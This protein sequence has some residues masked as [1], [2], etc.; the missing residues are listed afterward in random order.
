MSK[1]K[2]SL[3][4]VKDGKRLYGT[5]AILHMTSR[6]G[7]FD[8]WLQEYTEDVAKIAVTNLL[9]EQQKPILKVI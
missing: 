7:G 8:K 9:K 2:C 1:N 3:E 6:S 4:V 5:A